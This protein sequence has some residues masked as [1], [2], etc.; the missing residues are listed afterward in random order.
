MSDE[1]TA[2]PDRMITV[3]MI[4]FVVQAVVY[5]AGPTTVEAQEPPCDFPKLC[6]PEYCRFP[7]YA[8]NGEPVGLVGKTLM[9]LGY[10]LKLLLDMDREHELGEVLH[11]GIK[12]SNSRNAALSRIG[13]K[14]IALLAWLQE[15][16]KSGRTWG[17]MSS[18]AFGPKKLLR[19]RDAKRRPWRY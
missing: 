1:L 10:P 3:D 5:G 4:K 7:R 12:I 18:T 17:D 13:P 6:G 8:R 11:P 19:G 14:G 2:A 9:Q 16:Q 15:N